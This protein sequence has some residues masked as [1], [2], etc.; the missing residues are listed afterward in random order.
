GACFACQ[1]AQAILFTRR[2]E[3]AKGTRDKCQSSTGPLH[4]DKSERE[5]DRRYMPAVGAFPRCGPFPGCTPVPNAC[6]QR[7][8]K[9]RMY[10]RELWAPAAQIEGAAVNPQEIMG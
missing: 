3:I 1:R 5:L 9:D 6:G 4:R 10:R 7:E 8:L 2:N